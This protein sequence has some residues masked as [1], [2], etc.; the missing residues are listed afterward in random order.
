METNLKT[1]DT[2]SNRL[3]MY[4]DVPEARPTRRFVQERPPSP[5]SQWIRKA[6][7]DKKNCKFMEILNQLHIN[8]PLIKVIQQML[9]YS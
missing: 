6:K 3:D 4:P 5:F 2:T 9:K 8:I 1:H 7:E